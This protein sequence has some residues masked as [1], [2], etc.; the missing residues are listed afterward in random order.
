MLSG[1][2]IYGA[3]ILVS[4]TSTYILIGRDWRYCIG[5]LAL[6]YIGVFL[7]V[8]A[9]WP[10]EMAVA[11]MVAGWMAGAIL[12]IAMTS[13]PDTWRNSEKSIKFGLFFRIFAAAILALTIASLV[14]HSDNWLSMISIPLRWGSFIL[15]SFGLLQVSLTSHPLR[16]II[17]LLTSLSGFEIIYAAIETSTLVTGLLAGVNLGLA[18]IGAYMLTTPTMESNP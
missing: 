2:I 16:V 7:L 1:S 5:A 4:L 8:D 14:L 17:G 11:K 3:A 9:S 10:V 15:I 18:L 6:Q 13:A 12:G